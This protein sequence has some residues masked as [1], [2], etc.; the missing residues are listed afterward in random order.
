MPPELSDQADWYAENLAPHEPMIRGWLKSRY[1]DEIE[2]DDIVQE[3][4]FRVL[5]ENR[6]SPLKAPKAF[7]FAV[8]RNLAVDRV[9]RNKVIT[10]GSLW[11]GDALEVLDESERVEEVVARNHERELLTKAIQQLP[12]RCRQVFTLAKVYGM[13]HK[14]IGKELDISSHT[15]AAH[16]ATGLAKCMKFMKQHAPEQ[17]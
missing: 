17:F 2:V 9:R 11:D 13:S 14:Q 16:V 6:K 3:A 1:R 4:L 7:F 5:R 15:V 10:C 12:E 8:A